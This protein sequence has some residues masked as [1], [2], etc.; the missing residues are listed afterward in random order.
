MNLFELVAVINFP[1]ILGWIFK[2]LKLF[3]D[4]DV[5]VLRRFVIKVSVP[6]LI[7]RNLYNADVSEFGQMLPSITSLVLI[8][9]LTTVFVYLI[10]R[11]PSDDPLVSNSFCIG[12]FVGNYSYLGWGVLFYFYGEQGFT[13]GVFFSMFFWPVVL[14][15]GFT[16]IYFLSGR[17]ADR[18]SRSRIL[19]ALRSN[20]LPPVVSALSAMVLNY[21]GVKIPLWLTKS[22][23][24]L[25]GITI[26][27]ILFTVGLSFSLIADKKMVKPVALGTLVR[28]ILGIM[29]GIIAVA[30]VSVLFP[31][32]DTTTKKVVLMESVMPT[33]ATSPLFAD[34]I[35]SDKEVISGIITAST[36]F[37]LVTLPLWYTLIE[38]WSWL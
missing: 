15:T 2:Q 36:L 21:A 23:E 26:P 30:V 11:L 24:S 16:M 27:S 12:S 19:S 38:R 5:A 25:A 22:I 14:M 10:R 20:A 31:G 34:F 4:R 17:P 33:A 35:D 7:F 18:S 28:T 9:V 3:P 37:A 8:L 13:R 1:I 29:I 32:V 6:F